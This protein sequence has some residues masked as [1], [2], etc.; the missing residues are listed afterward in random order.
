MLS[1]SKRALPSFWRG[2]GIEATSFLIIKQKK[3]KMYFKTVSVMGCDSEHILTGTAI[4]ESV[5]LARDLGNAPEMWR[6][7]LNLQMLLRK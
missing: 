7:R 6:L 3:I 1:R 4:G 2:F 5:C